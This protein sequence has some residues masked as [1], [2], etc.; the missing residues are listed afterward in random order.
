MST[1]QIE[2]D[3]IE[4]AEKLSAIEIAQLC[5]GISGYLLDSVLDVPRL[6]NRKYI[7]SLNA[8]FKI[9]GEIITNLM[10]YFVV[11]PCRQTEKQYE[12]TL[13]R[14]STLSRETKIEYWNTEVGPGIP[15]K[16]HP[17]ISMELLLLIAEQ[18]IHALI[19]KINSNIRTMSKIVKHV[20]SSLGP[21][22][23][24]CVST[25]I[26]EPL[27]YPKYELVCALVKVRFKKESD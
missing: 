3:S 13:F 26:P 25:M 22:L 16:L 4:L 24:N 1:E 15:C 5:L 17:F 21:L 11:S 2:F 19:S 12:L 18:C 10:R 14:T 7:S 8:Y 6:H 23:Q 9:L 27:D 20:S